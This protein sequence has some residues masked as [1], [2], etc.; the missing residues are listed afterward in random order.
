VSGASAY[1]VAR[2]DDSVEA[3]LNVFRHLRSVARVHAS[4]ES[5]PPMSSGLALAPHLPTWRHIEI[6]SGCPAILDVRS[7]EGFR[8]T[9]HL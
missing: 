8:M 5:V 2:K 7:C 6:H 9:A 3:E 4:H 1:S